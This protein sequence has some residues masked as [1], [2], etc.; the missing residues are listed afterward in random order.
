VFRRRAIVV[1]AAAAAVFGVVAPAG[2]ATAV[3]KAGVAVWAR[4]AGPLVASATSPGTYLATFTTSALAPDRYVVTLPAGATRP[5]K[6]ATSLL[7][8]CKAASPVVGTDTSGRWTISVALACTRTTTTFT[9]SFA[10]A[11]SKAGTTS[12]AWQ[13]A[14]G[15][16]P[17]I[18]GSLSGP[19]VVAAALA[20]VGLSA[21]P[22]SI[23][24]DGYATANLTA[25][26]TD[27]FGN[28]VAATVAL[29]SATFTAGSFSNQPGTEPVVSAFTG[30]SAILSA[31]TADGSWTGS[32]TA[33]A[34]ST[35]VT[36]PPATVALTPAAI[37]SLSV[38]LTKPDP[39]LADAG[40]V[41]TVVVT[42]RDVQGR[43]LAGRSGAIS[44]T[45]DDPGS[46][47]LQP[48]L[49]NQDGT[50]TTRFRV[51]GDAGDRTIRATA[52]LVTG[53]AT[54]SSTATGSLAV[55]SRG[56]LF[57]GADIGSARDGAPFLAGSGV[58]S[59]RIVWTSPRAV[60]SATGSA[61]QQL[62]V[63]LPT[64][65]GS[66]VPTASGGTC[67]LPNKPT[68]GLVG[69]RSRVQVT[70]M[71][72]AAG[73]TITL[74]LYRTAGPVAE[75]TSFTFDSV[76][77]ESTEV[78]LQASQ[79]SRS[80]AFGPAQ[81]PSRSVDIVYGDKHPDDPYTRSVTL[82]VLK[83]DGT[84]DT[85]Y[86]GDIEFGLARCGE[87]RWTTYAVVDGVAEIQAVSPEKFFKVEASADGTQVPD[88]TRSTDL[89]A[90]RTSDG[91][92]NIASSSFELGADDGF[93]ISDGFVVQP[94]IGII[95]PVRSG[96]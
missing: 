26:P 69:Q 28:P 84:V 74:D 81:A 3:P 88:S 66:W 29:A 89:W 5:T 61:D 52:G 86:T 9:T 80:A 46:T 20:K 34:G 23:P 96:F 15:A 30:T 47:G 21:A 12:F 79:L 11:L 22:T 4:P 77:S 19:R 2:A 39:L 41:I 87:P 91:L 67:V 31:G 33:T 50:Y 64:G 8:G 51:S 27:A 82:T 42:A 92:S 48:L 49:D 6:V 13:V 94:R 1:L 54:Y 65:F 17:A 59:I 95:C 43:P 44:V 68:V 18:T 58:Q 70:G 40:S 36:S 32:V 25:T 35:V 62:D 7:V 16:S 38:A 56:E 14:K 71:V 55:L 83:P 76:L 73:G 37:A 90:A 72:C 85:E 78:G 24:A 57:T 63:L 53:S 93:L 75:G 60:P 10:T 45:Q